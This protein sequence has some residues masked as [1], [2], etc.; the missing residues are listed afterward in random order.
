M[1]KMS[2]RI[3]WLRSNCGELA[4]FDLNSG[5]GGG[6]GGFKEAGDNFAINIFFTAI[7][8]DTGRNTFEDQSSSA[9][10]QSHCGLTHLCL[11]LLT[12]NT[13]HVAFL[14]LK[15]KTTRLN[16]TRQ[17]RDHD[18]TYYSTKKDPP[19]LTDERNSDEVVFVIGAVRPRME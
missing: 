10:I 9:F 5:A 16:T 6:G 19:W 13:L 7:G 18:D 17:P 1:S 14:L 11:T 15:I 3:N 4:D 12:N 8:A 2:S